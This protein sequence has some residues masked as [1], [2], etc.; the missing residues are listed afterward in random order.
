MK[1]YKY[2]PDINRFLENPSLKLTPASQLNDPF[3]A[4]PTP[5]LLASY[6]QALET[7]LQTKTKLPIFT[8]LYD[9]KDN[10][11]RNGVISLSESELNIVMFTHYANE[12]TGGYLEFE[13]DELE[14]GIHNQTDLFKPIKTKYMFG[15]VNY[16]NERPKHFDKENPKYL[17]GNMYFDK[18]LSWNYEQEV[19]YVAPF[20]AV[21]C[22]IIPKQVFA[23]YHTDKKQKSDLYP[24]PIFNELSCDEFCSHYR[25]YTQV[26][27]EYGSNKFKTYA[28]TF[29]FEEEIIKTF[30]NVI[31]EYSEDKFNIKFKFDFYN[32][33]FSIFE[34]RCALRTLINDIRIFHPLLKV[35]ESKLTGIVLGCRFDQTTLKKELLSQFPNLNNNVKIAKLSKKF[36]EFELEDL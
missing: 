16:S 11:F 33:E 8:D 27:D 35:N 29:S 5:E 19:R 14:D 22:I 1:V 28:Q 23:D 3:E 36:Y 34:R 4:K 31:T 17:S 21:E 26:E 13:I 25:I 10:P 12:H 6:D 24:T 9:E 2:T 15:K 7:S 20:H 32:E 30:G 18:A